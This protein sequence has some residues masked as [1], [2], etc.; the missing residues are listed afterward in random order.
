[1]LSGVSFGLCVHR[2]CR[3]LSACLVAFIG[4]CLVCVHVR[5]R[6]RVCVCVCVTASLHTC[7][8]VSTTVCMY[9]RVY[10]FM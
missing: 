1:M 7:V 9:V 8:Y 2:V 6:V 10:V 3:F 4:V 5:V